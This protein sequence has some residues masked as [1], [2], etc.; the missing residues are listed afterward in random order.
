MK[1]LL[2]IKTIKCF[3]FVFFLT[4]IQYNNTAMAT[5]PGKIF[6][7]PVTGDVEPG[8]AA[9]IE[10]AL[11]NASTS[12]DD[13]CIIEMDTFGGR[14][15][16]ALKIVEHLLNIPKGRTLCYVKTKAISAGALIALACNEIVM[17]HSTT[18]GDCAP[19]SYSNDGPQ[20][21]G[22]KFQSPL[23]AKF[24]SLAKRNGYHEVL[25]EAMVTSDIEVLRLL[26]GGKQIFMEKMAY[27]E[28]SDEKKNEYESKSTVVSKGE[29]LT[30]TDVES[31]DLGFS[32]MSVSGM[33][34]MLKKM[35]LNTYEVVRIS[36]NWSEAFVRFIVKL[37]PILMMI[38]LAALYT[39]IKAP[40]F[41]VPG[42][43]GII[44]LGLVFGSQYLVGLAN[45]T[46]LLIIVIGI[47]LIG[48]EIFVIPGFGISGIT[49]IFCILA[50]M[51]LSLQD[52]VIPDP[53][54]P[55]EMDLLVKN[56]TQVLG[57]LLISFFVALGILRYI[58]PRLSVAVDGPY[59]EASLM[60][61]RAASSESLKVNVGDAGTA[62]TP[63]RPS[64]KMKSRGEILDVVTEGG[65]IE[66]G[67]S[68]VVSKI[69][70]NRII[71]SGKDE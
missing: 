20:M 61:A 38:G 29:L 10:R 31:V 36:E 51:V 3:L 50:G 47:I 52:F 46:E 22:E 12:K 64:G 56:L 2:Y 34:E 67:K 8:M 15:D 42:I 9:F 55:W 26:S 49:G 66:E 57:S 60:N 32:K 23:R 5:P 59:L 33:D 27:E 53:S 1:N 63:L 14:V 30:M 6:I 16:S 62:L 58:F 40:G 35:D 70:G 48:F 13:I 39:E 44:C 21:L 41:G 4:I 37:T 45:Y 7:I 19:I 68:V 54:F 71:V 25:A 24:R 17:K 43:L 11:T 18:I 28:L 65:F 69:S